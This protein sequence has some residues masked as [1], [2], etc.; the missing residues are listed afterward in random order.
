M[1]SHKLLELT[2]S[3]QGGGGIHPALGQNGESLR[4][5][6]EDLY[7]IGPKELMPAW[8]ILGREAMQSFL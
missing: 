1:E 7:I 8:G 6:N 3:T 2:D 4:Y 5:R